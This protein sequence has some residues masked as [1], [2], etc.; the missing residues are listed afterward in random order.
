MV[1]YALYFAF[2]RV[3]KF[4]EIDYKKLDYVWLSIA[5]IA[6]IPHSGEVR[7]EWFSMELKDNR[8][9]VEHWQKD[10]IDQINYGTSG[11]YCRTFIKIHPTPAHF[12]EIQKKYD[13]ICHKFKLLLD[14][15]KETTPERTIDIVRDHLQVNIE[16]NEYT[17]DILWQVN[18]LLKKS[19]DLE[20]AIAE[21]KSY[22]SKI[23]TY[24]YETLWLLLSPLFLAIA[25]AIRLAKVKGEIYIKRKS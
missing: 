14:A 9:Y 11:A 10:L 22:T 6:L 15:T 8:G 19:D 20:G 23:K 2:S 12:E 1:F 7:K 18:L 24:W 4:D 21:R 16:S 25:I 5:I 13:A 3:L 17:E